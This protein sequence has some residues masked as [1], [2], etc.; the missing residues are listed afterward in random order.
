MIRRPDVIYDDAKH[1]YELNGKKLLGVS[2]IAKVGEDSWGP[3]SWWGWRVGYEGA[4]E[5]LDPVPHDH[6][7]SAE[8]LR[9]ELK[10]QKKTP[11][12]V[13]D[14]AAK[15]GTAIHDALE[16]LA[17]KNEVPILEQFP[18]EEQGYVQ[19]L[20]R[21]YLDYRP[22]FVATEVQVVSEKHGFAGRYDIRARFSKDGPATIPKCGALCLIDLKTSK[23][24]YE[25]HFAQLAGY[26]IASVEMGY[27]AT[28][29]QYVLRV[30]R[31][32][33][34]EFVRSPAIVD[35]FL[36]RLQLAKSMNRL[37]ERVKG[38]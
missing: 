26:E 22:S 29:A 37:K 14:K 1:T 18:K 3:A 17:Q 32:G 11:N 23:R 20:C 24:V 9:A 2:S 5:I 16:H 7:W 30:D 25:S 15:R 6:Q 35:D 34:Y 10:R 12:H 27:P 8:D 38:A 19:G 21:W 33:S 4:L 13:R 36:A 31:D 28:D